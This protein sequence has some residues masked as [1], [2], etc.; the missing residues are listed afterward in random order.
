MVRD[1]SAAFVSYSRQ[2]SEFALRLAEDLKAAGANVW[3]DQL[4]IAPGEH[5]DRSVEEAL[6]GCTRMLVILS[7]ESVASDNVMDE[8]SF[9]LR[10]GK[11]IIPILFKECALPLRLHRKQH[12][13]F[14]TDYQRGLRELVR[15]LGTVPVT[16]K[17]EPVAAQKPEPQSPETMPAVVVA[18]FFPWFHC[19]RLP[20]RGCGFWQI[21]LP[22]FVR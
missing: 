12:I 21:P 17:A 11:A 20:D 2:D 19:V 13:D 4:D 14:R 15:A 22:L 8:V 7:P 9:A 1:A 5:W 18:D 6:R 16:G 3:L 10:S